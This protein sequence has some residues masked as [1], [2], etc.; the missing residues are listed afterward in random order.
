MLRSIEMENFLIE[1]NQEEQHLTIDTFTLN[2][3]S[4]ECISSGWIIIK[5]EK[6]KQVKLN[7]HHLEKLER[8]IDWKLKLMQVLDTVG[9]AEGILY[10][11]WKGVSKEEEKEID[12]AYEAYLKM[13]EK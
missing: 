3:E 5:K 4:K 11:P 9:N 13:K 2:R 6:T 8:K 10:N 12:S 1:I 7:V